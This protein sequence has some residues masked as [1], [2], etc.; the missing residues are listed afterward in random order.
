M[1]TFAISKF[2]ATM[3][4]AVLFVAS[5]APRDHAQDTELRA[6]VP[7][8]FQYGS[9]HYASGRYTISDL[10][11]R[12]VVLRSKSTTGAVMVQTSYGVTTTAGKLVFNRYGNRYFLE[13]IW[14]PHDATHLECIKTRTEQRVRKELTVASDTVPP[15]AVEMVSL[16]AAAR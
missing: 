9:D 4:A 6:D 5:L 10:S 2:C 12:F 16:Q 13:Q 14:T 3:A 8:A 15:A 7:F 1:S 11:D